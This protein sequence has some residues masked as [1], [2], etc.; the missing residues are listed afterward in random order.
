MRGK[1][2]APGVVVN[3][4]R[5]DHLDPGGLVGIAPPP[6]HQVELLIPDFGRNPRDVPGLRKHPRRRTV[7]DQAA[8]A[9]RECGSKH[10]RHGNTGSLCQQDRPLNPDG[11]HHGAD[12]VHALIES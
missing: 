1:R 8:H 10:G 2:R 11:V 5:S 12:I 4:A 6:L 7:R 9:L 3:P